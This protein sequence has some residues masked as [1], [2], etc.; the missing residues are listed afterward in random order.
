MKSFDV[1]TI[2]NGTRD[3]FLQS[4][5]F[6]VM[7]DKQRP[8]LED[9]CVPLGAKVEVDRV[10]VATGGGAT[11]AAATFGNFGFRTA[12]LGKLGMDDDAHAI[13]RDL[14][15]RR[16]DTSFIRRAS[17]MIT[18]LSVIISVPNH[19]RTVLTFRGSERT[20]QQKDL[21]LQSIQSR[22]LYLTS[23][24][25]NMPLLAWV[26]RTAQNRHM[27]IACNPGSDELH[28][29]MKVLPLL[30]HCAL[31]VLNYEEALQLL[32]ERDVPLHVAA[33]RL[34]RRLRT[35]VLITD[36]PR[37]AVAFVGS[38]LYRVAAHRLRHIQEWTGAGDAFGSG[39]L[40]GLL[41]TS[42]DIVQAL[43]YATA[44]AESVIQHIGAKTGLL[45][46]APNARQRIKVV[47]SSA[48]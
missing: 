38:T 42:G 3:I 22:W 18:P 33:T 19:G 44:N 7:R 27:P 37:G 9:F 13:L 46:K 20:L 35:M 28:H 24:A 47:Q 1:I 6:P 12:F 11:N 17:N 40:T 30:A 23:L 16:V 39:F 2:G 41:T 15:S 25:G 10:V 29:R 4:R 48:R 43:Q 8:K 32:G 26:I 45:K 14:V 31:V 5:D 34:G 36:G 21:P